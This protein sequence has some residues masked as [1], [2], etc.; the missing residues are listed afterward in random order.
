MIAVAI[1]FGIGRALIMS[2]AGFA[3]GHGLVAIGVVVAVVTLVWGIKQHALTA[4]QFG[5]LARGLIATGGGWAIHH[6]FATSSDIE[7]LLGVFSTLTPIA[8]TSI[9]HYRSRAD[10][11]VPSNK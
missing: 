9:V 8:W 3:L 10:D 5:S 4:G 6:G 2:G 1:A 11:K 7:L